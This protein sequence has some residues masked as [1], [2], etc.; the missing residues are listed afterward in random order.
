MVPWFVKGLHCLD[1]LFAR[2][3]ADPRVLFRTLLHVLRVVRWSP[4]TTRS[5]L[6]LHFGMVVNSAVPRLWPLLCV[7]G[8]TSSLEPLASP[9]RSISQTG[10]LHPSR[11]ALLCLVSRDRPQWSFLLLWPC[12]GGHP[13]LSSILSAQDSHVATLHESALS[14]CLRVGRSWFVAVVWL[15]PASA[16]GVHSRRK[17]SLRFSA[18]VAAAFS[19]VPRGQRGTPRRRHVRID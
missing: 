13:S 16:S 7:A 2:P 1:E 19:C 9:R 17:L 12:A 10:E 8:N 15:V 6:S 11:Q 3:R 4:S 5:E 18:A 14:E